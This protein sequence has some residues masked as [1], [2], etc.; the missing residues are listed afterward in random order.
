MNNIKKICVIADG[1]PSQN[2]IVN[3]FVEELI[4]NFSKFGVECIVIA[5]QSITKSIK[6]K[7][8]LNKL[9]RYEK[10][11]AVYS[12]YCITIPS[13]TTFFSKL[14]YFSFKIAVKHVFNKLYKNNTFDAIYSHFL[15]PAGMAA[16]FLSKKYNI[17][18]FVAYGESSDFSIKYLGIETTKKRLANINGVIAVSTKNKNILIQN[19]IF[20]N[21]IIHVFPNGVD[22]SVF[23]KSNSNMR[24]KL[25]IQKKDFIIIFVGRFIE[26]KGINTLIKAID[27]INRDKILVKSIFIGSGPIKPSCR[28]MI[29]SGSVPHH[30]LSE[31]LNMADVF[32]LPTKAEGCCNAIVEAMACGLPIISSNL[33]FNYDI[34]DNDNAIL[35]NPDSIQE[36][37]D[38]ILLLKN[39]PDKKMNLASN[40]YVKSKEL[41]I[42]TRAEQ[43]LKFMGERL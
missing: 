40:S 6:W 1:Y 33:P 18:S 22:H 31:Y 13:K 12:P 14:N 43:I 16:S 27:V 11:I 9:F 4:I 37:I 36:I 7:Y 30:K 10:N 34:L 21:S 26:S 32:I 2:R 15:F 35:I 28:G 17:P 38:A 24:N 20:S 3:T 5:P 41:D 39:N 8:K 23:N 19:S 29:F 42:K 25:G